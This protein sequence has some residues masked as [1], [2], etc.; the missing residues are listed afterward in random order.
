M[1]SGS[2]PQQL[3]NLYKSGPEFTAFLDGQEQQIGGLMR[4]LGFIK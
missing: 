2:Q 4:E 3:D 1:G